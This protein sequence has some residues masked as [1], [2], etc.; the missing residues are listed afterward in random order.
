M[1]NV[2]TNPFVTGGYAGPDYFCNRTDE[3]KRLASAVSSRRNITLISLRRMGKTGLLKHFKQQI[4]HKR[5]SSVVVYADLLPTMNCNEMLNSVSTALFRVRQKERNFMEKMFGLMASL[6]PRLTVD[7][8]TGEPAVELKVE[9]ASEIK[10]GLDNILRL[11]S[12]I[13]QDILFMFDEFQQIA[14]Y[15]EK[16]TEA[17]LR[18]VIQAYP[19][20]PFI[21]SGSSKHMLEKMFMS[22]GSP[23]YQ[24]TELM[25]LD[26]ISEKDY[27][28]FIKNHFH[29]AGLDIDDDSLHRIF[30]WTRLHTYY[31]QYVCSI[32]YEQGSLHTGEAEVNRIFHRIM[33][34]FEPQYINYRNLIP[35]HQFRLLKAIA[36]EDGVDQPTAGDFISRHGLTSP[37]SVSASLKS[38][39]EKEM[40]V[41]DQ[42][43]W[44]VYDVFFSRWL[45]YHYSEG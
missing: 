4:E 36:A 22:A 40:V 11:I 18:S 31:V 2:I 23:F 29:N 10:A 14:K 30:R 17:I 41:R 16:N 20:I 27:S 38:L 5:K 21:F 33:T 28:E 32:L 24:S 37:S 6:R 44:Q 35:A 12:E 43:M 7:P 34:D 15:P 8:L 9:T 19:V 13:R 1:K 45:Q 26:R 39:L 25:Y 3:T 42:E